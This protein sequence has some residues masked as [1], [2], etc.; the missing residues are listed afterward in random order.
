LIFDIE[1]LNDTLAS[2]LCSRMSVTVFDDKK[3]ESFGIT[4]RS[5]GASGVPPAEKIA[6]VP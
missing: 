1:Q 5:G 4:A 6:V 3:A 2:E